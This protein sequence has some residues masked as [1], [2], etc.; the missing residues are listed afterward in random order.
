MDAGL[1]TIV[2]SGQAIIAI[3][4]EAEFIIRLFF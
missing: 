4:I 3:K 1:A 2:G